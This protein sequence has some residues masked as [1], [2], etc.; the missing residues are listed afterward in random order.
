MAKSEI[1]YIAVK[2]NLVEGRYVVNK[3][4]TGFLKNVPPEFSVKTVG[5]SVLEKPINMIG[6]GSGPKKI[7]MWSQMHGNE[8]TTTK[9]VLDMINFLGR[10]SGLARTI[11]EN[12]TLHIIPILNPDGAEVYTRVN[13]NEVDLNRDAQNRDEPESVVL[14]EVYDSFK[15]NYCFNLHDQRTIFNVG[16]TP[17]PATVS[18]LA[19][20]HDE[21]RSISI[22]RAISMQL[23]AIMN[24]ELQRYIPGQIGRYDDA[25]NSNCAGDAFQM[26]QTPTVLLEAGHFPGDYQREKTREYIFYAMITGISAIAKDLVKGHSQ[27][28]YFK[29]PE[30]NKL[31]FDVLITNAHLLHTKYKA[32]TAIG[33][34]FK[35]VLDSNTIVFEPKIEKIGKLEGFYSHKIYNCLNN[36]DLEVL[37]KNISLVRLLK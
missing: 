4:I 3:D 36:N 13:A 7:L 32:G 22:T 24:N 30:N 15:P 33:I 34:L 2:E 16:D 20:A 18:F 14:R 28:E 11:K 26:L 35:E 17:R 6:I 8:S 21:K 5:R 1:D 12:C 23:I 37:T 27:D 9:A 31:F 29:I 19:P 25:F 10:T